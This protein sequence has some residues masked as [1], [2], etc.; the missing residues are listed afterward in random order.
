[1][2]DGR[3]VDLPPHFLSSVY[4]R[5]EVLSL[6]SPNV[7]NWD[8]W[9]QTAIQWSALILTLNGCFSVSHRVRSVAR[10][11][12]SAHHLECRGPAGGS[13]FPMQEVDEEWMSNAIRNDYEYA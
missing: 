1:M 4:F 6:G 9:A 3:D 13:G 12:P 10:A 11:H 5:I 7:G 2:V 8:S